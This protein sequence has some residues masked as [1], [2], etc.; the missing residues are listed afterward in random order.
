MKSIEIQITPDEKTIVS[1]LAKGEK[2]EDIA[3][4]LSIASGTFANTMKAIRA[5]YGVKNTVELV[6]YFLREGII[7]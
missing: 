6:A 4:D 2:A 7:K 3:A 5:K 1:R